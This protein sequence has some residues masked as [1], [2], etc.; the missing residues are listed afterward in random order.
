MVSIPMKNLP[1]KALLALLLL[2]CFPLYSCGSDGNAFCGQNPQNT[3]EEAPVITDFSLVDTLN[4][5]PWTLIFSVAFTDSNGDL[6]RLG[7]AEL[8]LN[9]ND[10]PERIDLAEIFSQS[11]ISTDATQGTLAIPLRFGE[12]LSD[13]TQVN[14][15]LQLLDA[16]SFRSN[17]YS[18]E[19][20]FGVEN[21]P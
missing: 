13:G 16:N 12:T 18:L 21:A 11:A 3:F 10:Q 15:G 14:L 1:T 2:S 6:G 20:F 8:F 19:L 4:G 7:K 9:G 5:D 17:C